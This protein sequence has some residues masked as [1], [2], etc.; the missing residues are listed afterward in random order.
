MNISS[1]IDFVR[2]FVD[3][4]EFFIAEENLYMVYNNEVIDFHSNKAKHLVNVDYQEQLNSLAP[5]SKYLVDNIESRVILSN[6]PKFEHVF[7]RVMKQGKEV[8]YDLVNENKVV[9]ITTQGY[10]IVDKVSSKYLNLIPSASSQAQPEPMVA[11]ETLLDLLDKVTNFK[12]REDLT[13]FTIWL[14]SLLFPNIDTPILILLGEQ[15]SGKSYTSDM[16]KKVIDPTHTGKQH[17]M[18]SVQ[19]FALLVSKAYMSIIDNLSE[20]TDEMSDAMCQT[21]S[22]GQYT[23]RKLYTSDELSVI[24]MK[25]KLII[26]GITIMNTKPDLLERSIVL[27]LDKLDGN[28]ILDESSLNKLFNELK[29]KILDKIFL[30]VS[31]VLKVVD[32]INLKTKPRMADFAQYLIAI[33]DYLGLDS[34]FTL[35]LYM[36]NISEVTDLI[37]DD[38]VVSALRQILEQSNGEFNGSA[39]DLLSN[40]NQLGYEG[41]P[42][43]PNSLS[44]KLT[45]LSSD[46]A[47]DGISISRSKDWQGNRTIKIKKQ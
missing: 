4:H 45:R 3:T 10:Q 31:H 9:V 14:V 40:M 21:V 13:L 44:A 47:K 2:N 15:G 43:A 37:I 28:K 42:K 25:S 38:P 24:S 6:I 5:S 33:G 32:G 19:D 20:I 34:K 39:S 26:N 46:L 7:H 41:L 17:G 12:N 29:P 1:N 11:D 22:K 30:A 18:K 35:D 16:A 8:I 27:G 23:T 36:S